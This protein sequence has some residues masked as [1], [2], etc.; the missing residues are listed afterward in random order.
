MND[1]QVHFFIKSIGLVVCF[2][3][4]GQLSF[5]QDSA[6]PSATV[7]PTTS[8]PANDLLVN[9]PLYYPLHARAQGTPLYPMD[10]W[11]AGTI[12]IKGEVFE[13]EK[14][15]FDVEQNILVLQYFV[16]G[17]GLASIDLNK[18]LVDSF[19][20]MGQLFI[21]GQSIEPEMDAVFYQRLYTGDFELWVWR[22]KGFIDDFGP[23]SPQGKYSATRAQHFIYENGK[24]NKLDNERS[25][26]KYFADEDGTI[27]KYLRKQGFY[28][29]NA[30]DIQ[31]IDLMKFC[32]ELPR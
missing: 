25:L 16:K 5:A 8:G 19:S 31:L 21:N 24:L 26:K 11:T 30:N 12:Y 28:F 18:N 1:I 15:R 13:V 14:L 32:D 17:L 27:K 2:L 4:V 9:G 22:K 23:Q 10:D 6:P 3:L 20:V 29:S 7:F